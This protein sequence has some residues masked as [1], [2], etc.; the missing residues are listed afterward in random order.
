MK[1]TIKLN[2]ILIINFNLN[3]IVLFYTTHLVYHSQ[4]HDAARNNWNSMVAYLN[5]TNLIRV[6]KIVVSWKKY[7]NSHSRNVKQK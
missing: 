7:W 6:G 2:R 1:I 5:G 3:I 4:N